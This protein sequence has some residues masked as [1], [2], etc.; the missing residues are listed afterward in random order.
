L[1]VASLGIATATFGAGCRN[2]VV[3]NLPAPC[4]EPEDGG[5]AG[6]EAGTG[7]FGGGDAQPAGSADASNDAVAPEDATVE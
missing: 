4:C 3:A 2:S 6:G 7:T 1:L 5:D